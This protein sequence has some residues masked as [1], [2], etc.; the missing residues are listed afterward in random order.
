MKTNKK[1]SYYRLNLAI[2]NL[3]MITFFFITLAEDPIS[4]YNGFDYHNEHDERV[5]Y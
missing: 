2:Q 3:A 5:V 1:G 4:F